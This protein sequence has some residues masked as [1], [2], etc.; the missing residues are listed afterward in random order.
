M[1]DTRLPINILLDRD[2]A[3]QNTCPLECCSEEIS[4]HR[5][6][7]IRGIENL[8][9]LDETLYQDFETEDLRKVWKDLDWKSL[10]DHWFMSMKC[11][12]QKIFLALQK[13]L[14]K[15]AKEHERL[16]KT[17]QKVCQSQIVGQAFC[18][19]SSP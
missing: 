12:K 7:T 9:R 11:S 10:S 2:H 13:R 8:P 16:K 6:N 17:A 1:K 3:L 15:E 4:Q 18:G 14:A 19:T 5:L